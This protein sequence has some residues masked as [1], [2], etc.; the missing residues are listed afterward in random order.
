MPYEFS[1]DDA[2]AFADYMRAQY[3]EKGDELT[4]EYCPRCGGGGHGDRDTFSINLVSGAFNCLRSSCDYHGHFVE[5]CRDFD[6]KLEIDTPKIYRQ[7]KQPDKTIVP[8]GTAI[9]YLQSRGISPKTTTKYE[10]TSRKDLKDVLVFPFFNEQGTLVFLKYRNIRPRSKQP[11]E[12]CEAK[13][14]PILFGMKQARDYDRPLVITEGQIDSL[15]VAEAGI[16]NAVSVPTGANGFTWLTPCY[17]WVCKFPSVIV[18]GDYENGKITLLDTLKARLP[19]AVKAVRKQDYLG[20]KDANAILCKYG[21]NAVQKAVENAEVPQLENV[22]DL[23]TVKSVDMDKIDKIPTG[24]L[25]VDKTIGGMCVGQV[26]LLTGKRGEGKSTFGSQIIANALEANESV[27]VYSG[28]LADFHFK[29]WLDYQLAGAENII[30]SYN[31]FG[32]KIYNIPEDTVKQISEWYRG[33]AYIYDNDFIPDGKTEYETLP[34]TIEKVVKQYGVRFVF[35]DNL[36]TAMDKVEDQNSLYLAQSN[37][38]GNLKKIAMKYQI[39]VLLVAHPRKSNLAFSNDDV[40]GSSDITNKVDVVMSYGRAEDGS[41]WDSVLQITKN[42]LWGKLRI[43]TPDTKNDSG[44]I[45]L[46]YSEAT[47]RIVGRYDRIRHYG[48]EKANDITAEQDLPFD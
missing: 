21:A 43:G 4:F 13:T 42:R 31:S 48:W 41:A 15:S 11:K 26:I 25:D 36:M 20:E 1:R 6:Y 38:V 9:E 14:M 32:T 46:N 27:F 10:V 5:L 37:F 40:S 24:I 8:N 39:V 16:E 28:E 45:V 2:F 22:K 35:I 47:K 34:E 29:R 33:R 12:W 17:E 44:G 19:M 18:F 30:E 7:L 3:H 23:S